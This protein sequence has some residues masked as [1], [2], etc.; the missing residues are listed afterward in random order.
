M[1][2]VYDQDEEQMLKQK[3]IV[4]RT[5]SDINKIF[6]NKSLVPQAVMPSAQKPIAQRSCLFKDEPPIEILFSEDSMSRTY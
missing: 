6:K 3:T 5:P 1:I 4:V 2:E